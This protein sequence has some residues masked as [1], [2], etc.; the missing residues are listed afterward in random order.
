MKISW[1]L[2]INEF[3]PLS[4]QENYFKKLDFEALDLAYLTFVQKHVSFTVFS[5]KIIAHLWSIRRKNLDS[6]F[7][8][9]YSMLKSLIK[10]EVY[11]STSESLCFFFQSCIGCCM[12]HEYIWSDTN[13]LAYIIDLDNISDIRNSFD[14]KSIGTYM[15][16]YSNILLNKMFKP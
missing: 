8:G 14:T 9:R 1:P 2:H 15:N 16:P 10:F 5:R 4:T 12:F 11:S 3:L 13:S 7:V 6:L